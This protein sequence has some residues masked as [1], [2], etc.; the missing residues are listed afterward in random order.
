MTTSATKATDDHEAIP[1]NSQTPDGQVLLGMPWEIFVL[2]CALLSILNLVL[3]LV[4]RN[5]DLDQVVITMDGVLILVFA[6]DFVRRMRVATDDRAYF[7]PGRG[8]L[9]L[10][11]IIPL[12]RIARVLRILRVSRI[13]RRM[14]GLERALLMFFKDKATG[15]LL[16]VVLI[17]IL[18][19]EF[20][21]LAVLFAERT[22]PD[23]NITT[24]GD[25][26]WYTVVTMSTVGYGDQYPV[27]ELGRLFGVVI[28]V[29]GVGVF[30][31][32]TGYLANIFLS[33]S[34]EPAVEQAQPAPEPEAPVVSS[35][36]SPSVA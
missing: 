19:L 18:V 7:G 14:G 12:L 3:E 34:G 11:S 33:P 6:I 13:V 25:A 35:P 27:T 1:W 15:G 21:S 29:V 17:A 26:L 28:I 22:S 31:T 23:A 8:W 5:P 32:L 10:V 4:I 36:E 30:G 24:A 20:G 2:G 9:D 16:L